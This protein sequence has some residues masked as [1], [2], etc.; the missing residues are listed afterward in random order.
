MNRLDM[1]LNQF[2]GQNARLESK[3]SDD[4]ILNVD[5]IAN[6]IHHEMYTEIGNQ[7][8][9]PKIPQPSNGLSH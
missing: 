6:L 2:L 9:S 7:F 8:F 3:F 5:V 4:Q 1:P